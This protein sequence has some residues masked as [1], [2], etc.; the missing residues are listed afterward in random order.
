MAITNH[1]SIQKDDSTILLICALAITFLLFFVIEGGMTFNWMA[2]IGSWILFIIYAVF[3]F[4]GEVFVS[5]ILLKK[6]E[7]TA[8]TLLSVASGSGLGILFVLKVVM[9]NW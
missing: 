1:K 7:S 4:M 3:I 2:N 9:S 8:Y 5:N 6:Y